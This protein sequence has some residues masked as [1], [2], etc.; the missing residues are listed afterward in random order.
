MSCLKIKLYDLFWF[1]FYK[2]MLVLWL[3]SWILLVDLAVFFYIDFF[4]I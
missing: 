1:A 3:K 4:S 2:V